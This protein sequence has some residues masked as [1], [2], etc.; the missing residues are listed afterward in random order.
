MPRM[1]DMTDFYLKLLQQGKENIVDVNEILDEI[2]TIQ[3]TI[4]LA[5][6]LNFPEV[7]PSLSDEIA[8]SDILYLTEQEPAGIVGTSKVGFCEVG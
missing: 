5:D 3:E 1:R 6:E 8:F 7:S 2:L 4:Q